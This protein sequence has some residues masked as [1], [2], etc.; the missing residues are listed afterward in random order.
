MY[1][2]PFTK[3]RKIR[4]FILDEGQLKYRSFSFKCQG[5]TPPFLYME[6]HD[7]NQ[8]SFSLTSVRIEDVNFV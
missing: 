8:D 7:L 6:W 5:N 4:S 3:I 1:L 2:L